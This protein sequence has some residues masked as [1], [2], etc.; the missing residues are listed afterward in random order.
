[1]VLEK[2]ANSQPALENPVLIHD[3]KM[4]FAIG[5]H[6]FQGLFGLSFHRDS[7]RRRIHYIADL[8]MFGIQP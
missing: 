3:A 1:M 7:R 8:G 4:A 2:T 6:P 5:E